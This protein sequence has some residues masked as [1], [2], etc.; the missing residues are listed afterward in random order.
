MDQ[1][2]LTQLQSTDPAE[3]REAILALA[4]S[5]D[6]RALKILKHVYENDSNL[7]LRE[8]A[9]KAAQHLWRQINEQKRSASPQ[10]QTQ[11]D[12][13]STT[14]K[15]SPKPRKPRPL[16]LILLVAA[17]IVLFVVGGYFVQAGYLD[18]Y[19]V[20]IQRYGWEKNK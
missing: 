8:L 19:L 11:K 10:Q 5:G 15:V 3:R 12:I 20:A 7:A 14:R 16:T 1:Q 6:S 18:R 4:R 13:I 2:L 9:K 17:L